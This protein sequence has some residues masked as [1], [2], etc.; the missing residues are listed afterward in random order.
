[1]G[2]ATRADGPHRCLVGAGLEPSDELAEVIRWYGSACDEQHRS[3]RKQG[4]G[5][6]I[7]YDVVL[8]RIGGAVRDMCIPD[9]EDQ[10]I[11]VG[12]CPSHP[13]GADVSGGTTDVL[14]DDGL[15]K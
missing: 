14:N 5:L 11:S 4:D 13:A 9:A 1:M 12:R 2:R 7:P 10:G 15:T 6:E 8:Q 3:I